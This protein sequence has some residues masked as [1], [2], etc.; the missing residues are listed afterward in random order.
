METKAE[1]LAPLP[2]AARPVERVHRP[3]PDRV[4]SGPEFTRPVVLTGCMEEWALFQALQGCSSDPERLAVL[5]G[6][7]KDERV[8]FQTLPRSARGQYHYRND[9]TGPS[10]E[11]STDLVPFDNF[12]GRLRESLSGRSEDYVYMKAHNVSED[13]AFFRALGENVLYLLRPEQLDPGVWIGSHGQVVN[14]HY[15]DFHNFICMGAGGKRVTLFPPDVMADIYH[16]PFDLTLGSA[17]A[18]QVRL[19]DADLERFPRFRRALGE[20]MV[21]VLEPGD[22]LYTPPYWWHHVE[23]FGFT[24]MV[25]NRVPLMPIEQYEALAE[26]VTRAI[27]LFVSAPAEVRQAQA[28]LYARQVFARPRPPAEPVGSDDPYAK[29]LDET[30]AL[31]EHFPPLILDQLERYYTHFVFQLNGEPFPAT[32]GE[33]EGMVARNPLATSF[34]KR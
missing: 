23:S 19:I 34:F 10:Y 16:G 5:D 14:L 7:M 12:S 15:D 31:A 21:T 9:L 3:S 22:V 6:L 29:H 33:L 30:R 24:V 26:N 4:W 25:N 27:R 13:S 2:F 32:P 17:C 8:C 20:A 11:T 18:S 1:D 28:A